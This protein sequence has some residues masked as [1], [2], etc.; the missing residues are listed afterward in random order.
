VK[1]ATEFENLKGNDN[2]RV[3]K[4]QL[5]IPG[6]VKPFRFIKHTKKPDK[7][8]PVEVCQVFDPFILKVELNK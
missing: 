7:L 8:S 6:H 3:Y 5:L 4:G 1:P 2:I